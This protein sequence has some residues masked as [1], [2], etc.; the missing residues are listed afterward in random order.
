V[1]AQILV[2]LGDV[3][4]RF[5]GR[6]A[7]GHLR[8]AYGALTDPAAKAE[9]GILLARTLVF[10]GQPGEATRFALAASAALPESLVDHRQGLVAL[11]RIAGFMHGLLPSEYAA[12]PRPEPVGDGLGARALAATLAWET[13]LTGEN[14]DQAI[15]YGGFAL[16]GGELQRVDAGLLWVVAAMSREMGGVD[17]M[18]FWDQALADAHERGTLF[19]ALATHLW[20]GYAQWRRG[21]LPEAY[22]SML[23]CTDQNRLY[24]A[25]EIGQPYTDA[26]TVWILLDRGEITKARGLVEEVRP[27]QRIGDGD[28]LFHEAEAQLL[29]AEGQYDDAL[30]CL[31]RADALTLTSRNPIWHRSPALRV[32]ALRLLGR[33]EE[34]LQLADEVV[35]A[36]RRWGEP[37]VI[38]IALRLRGEIHSVD[39]ETDLQD[40]CDLLRDGRSRL[41][42]ARALAA[43][44]GFQARS[45]PGQPPDAAA[46][47]TLQEAF[48]LAEQCRAFGLRRDLVDD[49]ARG[50]VAVPAEPRLAQQF[51]TTEQ[52]IVRMAVDGLGNR[53][54]AQA[55][56]MTPRTVELTLTSVCERLGAATIA[57]VTSSSLPPDLSSPLSVREPV[58]D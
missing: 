44:A 17:T 16:V 19:A 7:A 11:A 28:R 23:N 5:D 55:L 51:T 22:Q 27:R 32:E 26:M 21:D 40:A 54:I 6:A 56:F 15:D 41:E 57:E 36:A 43:Y 1:A 2:D 35:T 58:A 14:R 53:E 33:H 48:E 42:Y 34:A 29:I 38:G 13:V 31:D 37:E 49:L 9:A 50:G 25:P 18:P 52:R 47:A 46:M 12:G 20:R 45:R 8:Q 24:G 3:E 10:V 39:A 30:V 4:A